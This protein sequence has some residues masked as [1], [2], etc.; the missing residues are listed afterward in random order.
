[1]S[2]GKGGKLSHISYKLSIKGRGK[3]R[4]VGGHKAGTKAKTFFT[5]IHSKKF[6]L[7]SKENKQLDFYELN[8]KQVT[9]EACRRCTFCSNLRQ[10]ILYLRAYQ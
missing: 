7:L 3:S 9:L 4:T 5:L 10:V 2:L 8:S 6:Y 1:M